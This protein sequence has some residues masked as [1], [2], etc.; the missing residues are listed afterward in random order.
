MALVPSTPIDR[1]STGRQLPS[2]GRR[3]ALAAAS[4]ERE[5]RQ[6]AHHAKLTTALLKYKADLVAE[7]AGHAQAKTVYI[8]RET[9]ARVIEAHRNLVMYSNLEP[10]CISRLAD[11]NAV[12]HAARLQVA[13]M[14]V[15]AVA[16]TM[17]EL[18]E[19]V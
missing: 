7:L 6:A 18:V 13:T 9:D 8:E 10:E 12:M 16:H 5:A 11:V 4:R 17:A 15:A 14:A 3:E 2:V 1:F 19:S